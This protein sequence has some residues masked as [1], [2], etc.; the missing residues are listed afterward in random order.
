MNSFC[1]LRLEKIEKMNQLKL[2]SS[3]ITK[4]T[5]SNKAPI[6]IKDINMD[7][8]SSKKSKKNASNNKNSKYRRNLCDNFHHPKRN[9]LKIDKSIP[10]KTISDNNFINDSK[11]FIGT[12]RNIKGERDNYFL[13]NIKNSLPISTP[14]K[15]G[16]FFGDEQLTSVSFLGS[17]LPNCETEMMNKIE[18]HTNSKII[19]YEISKLYNSIKNYKNF[20]LIVKAKIKDKENLN[21]IINESISSIK[22]FKK[23]T[24]NKKRNNTISEK[25][26]FPTKK[27]AHIN[28][29]KNYKVLKLVRPFCMNKILEK[30][31]SNKENSFDINEDMTYYSL[32][33]ASNSHRYS[34]NN[35]L[36]HKTNDRI[37]NNTTSK[38]NNR[39]KKNYINKFNILDLTKYNKYIS[40]HKLIN[41]IYSKEA[42][43]KKANK[44]AKLNYSTSPKNAKHYLYINNS[45]KT[46]RLSIPIKTKKTNGKIKS[47]NKTKSIKEINNPFKY[48]DDNLS[49][50]NNK[51]T[52]FKKINNVLK[53]N[54][55]KSKINK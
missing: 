11:E 55:D 21:E 41:N 42:T 53:I 49:R 19:N 47:K 25:E 52:V 14:I 9:N 15:E 27:I 37:L 30:I 29:S 5:F 34:K 22:K 45:I 38:T 17:N 6:I 36:L 39:I 48:D 51:K 50:K 35:K 4:N 23:L 43:P 40:S 16:S 20:K 7:T 10:S 18:C 13:Y 32:N 26:I 54:L 2:P 44:K 46:P 33:F 1:C 24:S 12:S 28:K 8:I 31:K 3:K